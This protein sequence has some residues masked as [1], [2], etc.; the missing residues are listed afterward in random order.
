MFKVVFSSHITL[1][2]LALT[3]K[4]WKNPD[5]GNE[6]EELRLEYKNWSNMFVW[7]QQLIKKR[8]RKVAR[9]N[10]FDNVYSV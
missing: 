1:F 8:N 2:K 6:T 10:F 9:I 7:N 4:S 3:T 5:E